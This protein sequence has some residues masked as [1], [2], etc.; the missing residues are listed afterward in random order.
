V[1]RE[2]LA[3]FEDLI[4]KEAL[5]V[6]VG[7]PLDSSTTIGPLINRAQYDKV[8]GYITEAIDEGFR[9]LIGG[10]QR[11]GGLTHGYYVGPTV[12]SDVPP[13]ARIAQEEIFGPVLCL[14]PYDTVEQAID[15]TN[16]T[17]YGLTNY[18]FTHSRELAFDVAGRIRSGRV[19]LNGAPHNLLAPVGGYKQS[20]NGREQ[21][22]YG[23]EEFLEVKALMGFSD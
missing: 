16:A 3:E 18:I 11:P 9:L 21:G 19:Q 1:P 15:I 5:K 12:F 6:N 10:P 14:I 4:V 23:L 20:G 2:Q 7:D 8:R 17:I 13:S 22:T